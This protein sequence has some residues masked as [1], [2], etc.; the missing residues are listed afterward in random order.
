MFSYPIYGADLPFC[1]IENEN[2]LKKHH[3]VS[4]LLRQ[5]KQFNFALCSNRRC[6]LL[7]E[8]NVG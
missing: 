3:I 2:K 8:K 6:M 4:F 7:S 5:G 1:F